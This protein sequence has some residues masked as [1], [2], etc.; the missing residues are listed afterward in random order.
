MISDL[1]TVLDASGVEDCF[2]LKLKLLLIAQFLIYFSVF[3]F[4]VSIC[5]FR[6]ITEQF[7]KRFRK[8]LAFFSAQSFIVDFQVQSI[9]KRLETSYSDDME[10]EEASFSQTVT[11]ESSP[12]LVEHR[13]RTLF[14]VRNKHENFRDRPPEEVL[15][16][17]LS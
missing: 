11:A 7:Y 13:E 8:L 14:N 10:D 5:R 4:F 2:E 3:F 9:L 17:R 16:M 12:S 6:K 1:K 15:N